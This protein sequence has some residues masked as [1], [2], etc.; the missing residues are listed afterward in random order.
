MSKF[1]DYSRVEY[2]GTLRAEIADWTFR[3]VAWGMVSISVT[4]VFVICIPL[5]NNSILTSGTVFMILSYVFLL[6]NPIHSILRQ[7]QVFQQINANIT[8]IN[9]L[10][11]E[12]TKIDD[13]IGAS[14][15]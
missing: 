8:R 11:D 6:L 3:A 9:E 1:H 10:F 13:S 2:K 7:L 12:E 14:V 4:L 15:L 5:Y